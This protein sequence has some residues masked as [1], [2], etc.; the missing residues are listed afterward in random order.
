[1]TL[2]AVVHSV[3][4]LHKR[5]CRKTCMLT[6]RISIDNLYAAWDFK[7]DFSTFKIS[8]CIIMFVLPK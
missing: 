4:F 1:M 2:L 7:I 3:Y 8:N 5:D 6:Q